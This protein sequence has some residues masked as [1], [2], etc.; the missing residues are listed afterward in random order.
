MLELIRVVAGLGIL[1]AR[2]E[3]IVH[4]AFG[5]LDELDILVGHVCVMARSG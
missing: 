2:N 4:V 5:D 3:G 1:S